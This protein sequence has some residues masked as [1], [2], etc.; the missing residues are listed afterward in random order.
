M[1]NEQRLITMSQNE[2]KRIKIIGAVIEKRLKQTQAAQAL[3]LGKRQII[4][5]VEKYRQEGSSSLVSKLRGKPSNRQKS[6]VIKES[7]KEIIAQKYSDFGPTFAAEKLE[8]VEGVKIN[9]E[10]LRQWMG[11]WEFWQI[12]PR[13]VGRLHQSRD[14]RSR[15]GELVQIDGSPHDWFEGRRNKCCL[16]VFIDDATSRLLGLRFEETECSA[17]YFKLCRSSIEKHGRPLAYYS[18]KWS[19]FR[20]NLPEQEGLTQFGRALESL[21][22]AL[23]CAN[24]PQAKGRVERANK[25]LQDRLVKELRLRGINDLEAANAYLPIFIRDY[26]RRFSVEPR[27]PEDAHRRDLPFP[28]IRDLI[29]SFQTKRKISKQLEVSYENRL[30][31]IQHPKEVYRLQGKAI[32]VCESVEGEIHLLFNGKTLLFKEHVRQLR[33]PKIIDKKTLGHTMDTLKDK[34][35]V[36]P[37]ATHPWKRWVITKAK[38]YA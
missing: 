1:L 17:G 23:I 36:K 11:E 7:I 27:E 2:L 32:L 38:K 25:T 26:N 8:E 12:K 13:K 15:F 5:L 24:S 9:K 4:R 29:F 19:G 37:S 21:D 10:T 3:N 16:L 14:R 20:Q 6:L 33:L 18:D 22:I 31:Q 35:R 34:K 28:K 30:F